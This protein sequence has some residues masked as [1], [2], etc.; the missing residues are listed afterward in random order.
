MQASVIA[1]L[2]P[3]VLSCLQQYAGG[4]LPA[5]FDGR[6]SAGPLDL[7]QWLASP[8]VAALVDRAVEARQARNVAAGAP[9]GTRSVHLPFVLKVRL[10]CGTQSVAHPP[11]CIASTNDRLPILLIGAIQ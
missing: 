3:F 9:A 2:E 11:L 10:L 1:A 8:L 4:A 6:Y 5:A 7:A